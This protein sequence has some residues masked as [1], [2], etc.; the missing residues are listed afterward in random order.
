MQK[1]TGVSHYCSIETMKQILENECLRFSDIRYLNDTTEFKEVI[2]LIEYV[3]D[4]EQYD[5]KFKSFILQSK[6]DL[7]LND[8][9]QSYTQLSHLADQ[10]NE[11]LYRTYTFSVSTDSDSLNMWNY[12]SESSGVNIRFNH[13]WNI[14]EGSSKREVNCYDKLN[15]DII[16]SRGVI[17]YKDDDKY[18]CVKSLMDE[19]YDVYV[20]VGDR[21]TEYASWISYAFKDSVN[22]MRCFFKSKY[23]ADERE[24]RFVLRIPEKIL[25][26]DE[27]KGATVECIKDKGL[28]KRGNIFIPYID[29]KFNRESINK[30]IVNPYADRKNDIINYSINDILWM[31]KYENVKVVTS[32]IPIRKY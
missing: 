15:N 25:I 29:Y 28:F 8:Y 13:V 24:Y 32:N 26:S 23:F 3:L 17:L 18:K 7:K 11:Q 10:E 5:D 16:I 30:I 19:L 6:K 9:M 4:N 2:S 27:N 14:F 1:T 22:H 21:L 20:E 31:E 12:Y